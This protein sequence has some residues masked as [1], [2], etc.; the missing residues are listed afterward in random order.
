MIRT[1]NKSRHRRAGFT[2]FRG[3]VW[4]GALFCKSGAAGLGRGISTGEL[5]NGVSVGRHGATVT[6]RIGAIEKCG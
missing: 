3:R 1:L 5:W 2:S 4:R 6:V